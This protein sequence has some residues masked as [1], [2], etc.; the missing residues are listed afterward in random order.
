MAPDFP[1]WHE[2]RPPASPTRSVCCHPGTERNGSM[3]CQLKFQETSSSLMPVDK[4]QLK[5]KGDDVFTFPWLHPALL[6]CASHYHIIPLT[7]VEGNSPTQLRALGWCPCCQ[8]ALETLR[9]LHR[10]LSIAN[11]PGVLMWLTQREGKGGNP[12]ITNRR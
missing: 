5:I 3:L 12:I 6:P 9:K 4:E 2:S 11:L 10:A 7:K 1:F 8:V